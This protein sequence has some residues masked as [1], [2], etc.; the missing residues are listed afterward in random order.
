MDTLILLFHFTHHEILLKMVPIVNLV[1]KTSLY[2]EVI[3]S[4]D[5]QLFTLWLRKNS[6][7]FVI[8]H[9]TDFFLLPF[10]FSRVSNLNGIDRL[11]EYIMAKL[12][13]N[14][15]TVFQ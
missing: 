5:F 6:R 3:K 14:N 11:G 2:L 8:L 10:Y 15:A 1:D 4:F 9:Y 13:S 7:I 12:C